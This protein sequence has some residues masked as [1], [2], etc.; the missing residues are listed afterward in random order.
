MTTHGQWD[1]LT[2]SEN[3]ST[4]DVVYSPEFPGVRLCLKYQAVVWLL[5]LPCSFP[6]KPLLVSPGSSSLN[7]SFGSRLF[8]GECGLWQR[9]IMKAQTI[10]EKYHLSLTRGS[11]LGTQ[12]VHVFTRYTGSSSVFWC[13]YWMDIRHQHPEKGWKSLRN[14]RSIWYITYF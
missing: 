1:C 3:R 14:L 9:I 12:H 6:L 7:K 4:W 5:L 13:N 8:L 11:V 2:G 10:E